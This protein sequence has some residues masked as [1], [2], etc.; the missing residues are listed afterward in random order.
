MATTIRFDIDKAIPCEEY[1]HN[2]LATVEKLPKDKLYAF[3]LDG[4]DV[5]SPQLQN[6]THEELVK[7]VKFAIQCIN[8]TNEK[9][10]NEAQAEWA[11]IKNT[12]EL[13][14]CIT[15]RLRHTYKIFKTRARVEELANTGCIRIHNCD[16]ILHD[17]FI[18][19]IG[20]SKRKAFDAISDIWGKKFYAISGDDLEI[21]C[22]NGCPNCPAKTIMNAGGIRAK[23][24]CE[25]DPTKKTYNVAVRIATE[26][27][28]K[29]EEEYNKSILEKQNPKPKKICSF[30]QTEDARSKCAKCEKA[31][32]CDASCQAADWKEHRKCCVKKL[33]SVD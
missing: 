22:E 20:S 12:K 1:C 15:E 21:N 2:F 5:V 7:R 14:K 9:K 23:M 13:Y 17:W 26:E 28:I 3:V 8:E 25:F 6:I 11:A 16:L 27:Y 19:E 29:G 10:F 30:C 31:R 4:D 24:F 18:A 32:Y 33:E